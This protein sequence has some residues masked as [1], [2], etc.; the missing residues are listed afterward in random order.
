M[1][2]IG[3]EKAYAGR[4]TDRLPSSHPVGRRRVR[5]GWV[6]TLL[7]AAV[8]LLQTAHAATAGDDAPVVVFAAASLKNAMDDASAAWTQASGH[9]AVITYAGSNALA[10]QIAQGA[11]AD[12]FISADR[13]WMQYVVQQGLTVAGSERELLGNHL[14]LIAPRDS[15]IKLH[16]AAEFPLA[17]ALGAEGRLAM[18]NLAVPAGK[19]AQA[20]LLTLGVWSQ[21][22]S[23]TAQAE[24]VRAALALVARQ[25]AP[26]GVVYATDA[27]AEPAVRVVDTFPDGIYPPVIY[28]IAQL[29]DSHHPQAAAF[30]QFL[31]SAAARP[32]FERQGF[33]VLAPQR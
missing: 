29:K 31:E 8:A 19:Y 13:D 4:A 27:R 15:S 24:N 9:R 23:R 21:V 10:K 1:P 2:G 11:P 28:P 16:I 33:T 20:A 12:V 26:L 25:E 6:T 22:E 14:V 32:L 7:A 30:L 5:G 17:A 3:S 18:C